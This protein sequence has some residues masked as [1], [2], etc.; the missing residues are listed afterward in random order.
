MAR[1]VAVRGRLELATDSLNEA[2]AQWERFFFSERLRPGWVPIPSFKESGVRGRTIAGHAL[3]WDGRILV[4]DDGVSRT[5]LASASR[6]ARIRAADAMPALH[7]ELTRDRG[8]SSLVPAS[9]A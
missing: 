9:G 1:A 7:R 2:L 4:Y 3:L 6:R 5:P 8:G